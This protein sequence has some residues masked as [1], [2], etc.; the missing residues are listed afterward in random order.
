M[1]FTLD[2]NNI[3]KKSG[4]YFRHVSDDGLIHLGIYPVLYGFRVRAGYTT[5]MNFYE[6]D[7][8]GGSS[9]AQ[10][11]RLFDMAVDAIVQNG[12]LKGFPTT[13]RIK[14]FFNDLEFI[15]TIANLIGDGNGHSD[16]E[17]TP[18]QLEDYRAEELKAI[19]SYHN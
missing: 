11:K 19:F 2:K 15:A 12:S 1:N 10:V 9:T 16:I 14:P 8:C 13:S 7:W 3:P 18:N 4:L 6:I 17:I 5:D